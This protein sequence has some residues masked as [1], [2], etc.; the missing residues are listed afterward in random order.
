MKTKKYEGADTRRVLAAMATNDIVCARIAGQWVDE[1]L[2]GAAWADLVGALIIKHYRKYQKAPGNRMVRLYERWADTTQSDDKTVAAIEK[3]LFDLSDASDEIDHDNPQYLFDLAADVFNKARVE[4]EIEQ[5]KIDLDRGRI[6]DAAARIALPPVNLGTGA[7]ADLVDDVSVWEQA[8]SASRQRALVRYRGVLGRFI[9]DAFMRGTFHAF[10]AG[11]K[12]GKTA[13]LIDLLYRAARAGNNVAFFDAGDSIEEEIVERLALRASGL[14]KRSGMYTIPTEWVEGDELPIFHDVELK[15]VAAIDAYRTFRRVC[16]GRNSVRLS[17][18]A[19]GTLSVADIEGQLTAWARDGWRSDVVCLA[20]GSMVLTERGEVPIEQIRG[21]DRLWDGV[22]WVSHGGLVYKGVRRVI[23]YAGITAT[24]DH[25]VYSEKGWRTL[26]ESQRMGLRI[27]KTGTGRMPIRLVENNFIGGSCSAVSISGR[28]K[29]QEGIRVCSVCA[30][31]QYEMGDAGKHSSRVGERLSP[32]FAAH[33][34]FSGVFCEGPA[35]AIPLPESERSLLAS[36]R[37]KGDTI[38][39]CVPCRGLLVDDREFGGRAERRTGDRPHRQRRP[40]RAWEHTIF[41]EA[42]ELCAHKPGSSHATVASFP[43]SASGC[44]LCGSDTAS[45]FSAGHDGDTDCDSVGEEVAATKESPVWDIVNAGPLHRFTVQGALVH[46]CVD[47]AD[48]LA[49]PKG[50]RD[51]LE[52]ID[53]TWLQL[54]RL[55]QKLRVLLVTATQVSATAYGMDGL[56]SQKHFQGRRTK[57]AHVNGMIGINVSSDEKRL[58]MG[59]LNWVVRRG[60]KYNDKDFVRF[61]GSRDLESPIIF[62]Q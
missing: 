47:Y 55:S 21:S 1:G 50:I 5:A 34:I 19:S 41:D 35:G 10:M 12:V 28:E 11:E 62:S 27:A 46:N 4:R 36:V 33:S 39:V 7:Y 54:R 26:I 3:F 59:R 16:R 25:L 42:S 52:Q 58:G 60:A 18:H 53:E 22:R 37:G 8:F 13:Y 24:P 48:I 9:G 14:P 51:K 45:F 2:F 49:P 61:A 15:R 44:V 6:A 30:V 40:L 29:R 32:V 20:S 43:Y 23:T 17:C 38:S 57:F 31:S 56:L